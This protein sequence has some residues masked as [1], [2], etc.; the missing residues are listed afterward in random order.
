MTLARPHNYECP[1]FNAA[2]WTNL[3]TFHNNAIASPIVRCFKYDV[4]SRNL[5]KISESIFRSSFDR[6]LILF[7]L[8]TEY[9]ALIYTNSLDLFDA[10]VFTNN[11]DVFY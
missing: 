8:R 3:F 5:L 4:G 1:K 11:D 2:A 10:C 7:Y 9:S 6:E